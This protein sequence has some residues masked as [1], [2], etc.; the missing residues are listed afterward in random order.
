M[1]RR[2]R[3]EENLGKVL[4]FNPLA[5]VLSISAD[6]PTDVSITTQQDRLMLTTLEGSVGLRGVRADELNARNIDFK[7]KQQA[8]NDVKPQAPR[9]ANSNQQRH[10]PAARPQPQP[11]SMPT[12]QHKDLVVALDVFESQTGQDLVSEWTDVEDLVGRELY[13]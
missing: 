11:A 7:P 3:F 5:D 13:A 9:I 1:T 4:D 12:W 10:R 6:N 8:S 2:F